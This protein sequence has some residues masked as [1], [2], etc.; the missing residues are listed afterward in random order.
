MTEQSRG[1]NQTPQGNLTVIH[2]RGGIIENTIGRI[3]SIPTNLLLGTPSSI[4]K[5]VP[6]EKVH[7]I[8]QR[9]KDVPW[10]GNVEVYLNH[11]PFFRRIKRLFS[12]ERKRNLFARIVIGIPS[13]IES[14]LLG[15]LTR[16]DHYEPFTE[17]AVVFNQALGVAEHE[18][19][20]AI[21][22]DQ[23]PMPSL[24]ALLSSITF[25]LYNTMTLEPRASAIAMQHMTPE[26]RLKA[27]RV[28]EPAFGSYVGATVT[29]LTPLTGGL[30]LVPYA[31]GILAGHIHSRVSKKNFFFN[32][33]PINQMP[34]P[35]LALT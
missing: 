15:K 3:G 27:Q 16:A 31:A 4:W 14:T 8:Q 2:K 30:S 17:S 13:V 20:H 6:K 19:G 26:E 33:E 7:E 10:Q 22:F 28:L 25:P 34:K 24:K 12:K 9:Y 21:D 35:T 11:A 23:S 1:E 18:I 29:A 32:G 5:N